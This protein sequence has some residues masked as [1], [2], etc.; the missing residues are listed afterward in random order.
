MPFVIVIE[1]RPKRVQRDEEDVKKMIARFSSNLVTN[2]FECDADNQVLNIATGVV[3]PP[4]SG[5]KIA[6]K[7]ERKT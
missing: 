7:L 2:P 3:L 4:E 1:E 6:Q 5:K